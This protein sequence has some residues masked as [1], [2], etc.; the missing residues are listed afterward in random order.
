MNQLK[1]KS[2]GFTLHYTTRMAM[3]LLQERIKR[4]NVAVGQFPIL[5][6][7][8]EEQGI[9]QKAL[10]DLIRVEQPTLANTLKRMERD[11]LIKRVPD[12]ED[13]RQ[14]RI[15]MT[16]RALDIKDALQEASRSVNEII[17]GGMNETEQKEFMRLIGIITS[18][19]ENELSKE[20]Q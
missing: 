15:Y 13:K 3:A 20:C 7:L 5:A 9:T 6:H 18:T 4:H 11:G 16:Q 14:W 2:L 8:W 19:L 17:N 1:E 12:K 10:C